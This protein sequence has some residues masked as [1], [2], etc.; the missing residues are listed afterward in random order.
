MI[1]KKFVSFGRLLLDANALAYFDRVAIISKNLPGSEGFLL[2]ANAL[3]YFYRVAMISKKFV[4]CG[5]TFGRITD[6]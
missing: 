4:N 3:A 2:D 5:S 6:Y 1:T